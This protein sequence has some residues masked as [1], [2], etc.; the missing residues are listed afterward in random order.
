L[1]RPLAVQ[2]LV[3]VRDGSGVGRGCTALMLH[4]V[5]TGR[6]LPLAW[7]VRQAPKGHLPAALPIALVDLSS[8]LIPAGTPGVWRGDGACDGTRLQQRLQQ[9]GWSYACRT[10]TRTVATWEGATCR[11]E[12]LGSCL[13]PGR[14]IEL[15]E[16]HG[17]R[18]AYG[19]ILGLCCGAK[20]YQEPRYVVR[21]MATAEAA[22]RG[23]EKRFRIETF[24][25]DQKSRGFPMHTSHMSDV[26]RLSRLFI[27]ACLAYIWVVYLGSVGAKEQWRHIIHRRTRCDVSLFQLGLRFLEYLLNEEMAIPVQFH[28]TI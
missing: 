13:K 20:G 18:E 26:Q 24:F 4:V 23:D 7:R 25:A 21:N 3:L 27:A 17:T 14:L 15:Q 8:G 6:A 1:L 2:T 22:C 9:A 5:Y 28:V 11:L 16:V 19:P 12:A 10:A